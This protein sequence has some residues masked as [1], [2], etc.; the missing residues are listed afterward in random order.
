[1][2]TKRRN[3]RKAMKSYTA[4][5]GFACGCVTTAVVAFLGVDVGA[6]RILMD[7]S[8]SIHVCVA[9]DGVMRLTEISDDCPSGQKSVFLKKAEAD[10]EMN[11]QTEK[12]AKDCAPT[13]AVDPKVLADF[14]RRVKALEDLSD[15]GELGNRVVAPFEVV[16]RAGQRVF[17]VNRESGATLVR[18]YN[19]AG[20]PV[21]RIAATD[22]GG[23]FVGEAA[24]SAL[25]A[26][27]GIF[28]GGSAA[29]L[30]VLEQGRPRLDLGRDGGTGRYRLKVFGNNGSLAAG[31]GQEQTAGS[32]LA[33]VND[34]AGRPRASMGIG[35]GTSRGMFTIVNA[36]GKVI[37]ELQEDESGA[38]YLSLLKSAGEKMVGAGTYNGVGFVS[39]GPNAFKPGY[40]VLGLPASYIVGKQ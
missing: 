3:R 22:G 18:L 19:N 35:I 21:A 2:E 15:R 30:T 26:Y 10:L 29:G 14:D 34:S 24:G 39:T 9:S 37:S 17:Y 20:T 23:Q 7:P 28:A 40:G 33:V 4:I 36:S 1:M 8:T 38:G 12:P 32:G 25:T 27:L 6:Q 11:D 5:V 31:I 13:N 16:D